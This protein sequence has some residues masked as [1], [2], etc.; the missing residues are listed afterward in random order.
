MGIFLRE[1]D[2]TT[3]ENTPTP[4]FEEPLKFIHGCI[5][6]D[7]GINWDIG[8]AQHLDHVTS[9]GPLVPHIPTV[10]AFSTLASKTWEQ[11]ST[12]IALIF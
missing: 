9:S 1:I 3:H 2:I 8:V 7:Y 6:R 5:L 11:S 12:F 10:I 4:L